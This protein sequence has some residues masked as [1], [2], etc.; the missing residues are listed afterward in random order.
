[1]LSSKSGGLGSEMQGD[2]TREILVVDACGARQNL[3][4]E[5]NFLMG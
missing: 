5:Q 2:Q 1:M 4:D 3:Q